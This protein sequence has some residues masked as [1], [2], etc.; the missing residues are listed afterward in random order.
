MNVTYEIQICYG[1]DERVKKANKGL[2]L[3]G[4]DGKIVSAYGFFI[5]K[6]V[7]KSPEI[8]ISMPFNGNWSSLRFD[9]PE[10]ATNEAIR[11]IE[12]HKKGFS[13]WREEDERS[14]NCDFYKLR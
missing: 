8:T 11:R 2:V 5:N 3:M 12:D 13:D 9:T 4:E 7:R 10:E 14:I 6:I 1:P